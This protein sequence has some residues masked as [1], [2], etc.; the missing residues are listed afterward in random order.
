M[1]IYDDRPPYN[2]GEVIYGK[3]ATDEIQDR[4]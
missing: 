4:V 2:D 1:L 3:T